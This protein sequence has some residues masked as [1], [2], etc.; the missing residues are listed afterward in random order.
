MKNLLLLLLATIAVF[1]TFASSVKVS[2]KITD[3]SNGEPIGGAVVKYGSQGVVSNSQGLYEIDLPHRDEI[4][5]LFHCVGYKRLYKTID[6]SKGDSSITINVALKISTHQLNEFVVEGK[7]SDFGTESNQMSALMLTQRQISQIP[8]S[9][10]EPDIMKALQHLPGVQSAKDGNA[11]IYVRGGDYDQN[12]ITLDGATVYSS[13]HMKGFVSVF[14]PDMIQYLDFYRGAFPTKYGSRISSIVDITSN[15]GNFDDYSGSLTLGLLTAKINANGPILKKKLSFNVSARMSY[16]DLLMKPTYDKYYDKVNATNPMSDLQFYDINAKFAYRM[17][18]TDKL[19]ATFFYAYDKSKDAPSRNT[20]TYSESGDKQNESLS[21]NAIATRW[22]NILGAVNWHHITRD[23][24]FKA[25]ATLSYSA[26]SYNRTISAE[27]YM[28]CYRSDG[29][30]RQTLISSYQENSTLDLFSDISD[31]TA[32]MDF[33]NIFSKYNSIGYG[34]MATYQSFNPTSHVKRNSTSFKAEGNRPGTTH[35]NIDSIVGQK[36]DFFNLSAYI[37]DR[38][39]IG[40]HLS[41]TCGLRF[42]SYFT[43]RKT[44]L[45]IEPRASLR[46]LIGKSSSLK[47]AYSRM[48]QGVRLLS[49]SSL[50]AP[51]DI[52]I[53][54]TDSIPLLTSDIYSMAINQ[55]LPW[56]MIITIEGFY[57]LMNNVVDYRDGTSYTD[58]RNDWQNRVAIGKGRAYGVEF[59]LQKTE[60]NTTGWIS[61]TWSKSLRKFNNDK[62]KLNNGKEFYSPNDR[63]HNTSIA[64]SHRFDIKSHPGNHI[65]ISANWSYSTG[66]HITIPDYAIFTAALHYAD[67]AKL[68]H[69]WSVLKGEIIL[70]DGSISAPYLDHFLRFK[71]Y[72]SRNNFHLPPIHHLDIAVAITV[73]HPIGQSTFTF[74]IYN[75]YNRKNINDVYYGSNESGVVLK[76]VCNFPFMP[77]LSYCYKF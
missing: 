64:L 12:L 3:G 28:K 7:Y 56:N 46:V 4:D 76:G 38:L 5:L 44:Y 55:N 15:E 61:Y 40:K 75:V 73:V 17:S 52:W 65:D 63:R 39:S 53:P 33:E 50:V 37:E 49:S 45:S 69:Q 8:T 16:Y 1:E 68:A 23:E 18:N 32:A 35:E 20:P 22:G 21:N 70:K 36:A 31:I 43:S 62:A 6:T 47:L 25:H 42:G 24:R 58:T 72:S 2:G 71:S 27:N 11:G 67:F 9:F 60:G 54:I 59:H 51:S 10:G 19:T 14:N 13:E 34:A 66:R 77:N 30:S 29:S 57:K 48:A 74:G 41:L 26:Y